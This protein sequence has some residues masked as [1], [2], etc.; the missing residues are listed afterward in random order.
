[1]LNN[2]VNDWFNYLTVVPSFVPFV[3]DD[4]GRQPTEA[5]AAA[6]DGDDINDGAGGKKSITLYLY[7][8]YLLIDHQRV[9]TH[10]SIHLLLIQ[11]CLFPRKHK[12]HTVEFR[13]TH[14]NFH[15]LLDSNQWR[16]RKKHVRK[17]KTHTHTTKK[18][19][20]MKLAGTLGIS[21]SDRHLQKVVSLTRISFLKRA[22][23]NVDNVDFKHSL[24]VKCASMSSCVL[25]FRFRHRCGCC[26]C[27]CFVLL[28][29]CWLIHFTGKF[30]QSTYAIGQHQPHTSRC[31][32]LYIDCHLIRIRRECF[33]SK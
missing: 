9:C 15:C 32:Y 29:F 6:N 22:E 17:Q 24:Y 2:K 4:N 13:W 8:V 19:K 23:D 33:E 10:S 20:P 5:T 25:V 1:M 18:P 3:I 31:M 26:R 28:L 21:V 27:R 11:F 16:K 30:I 12:K 14:R 7:V